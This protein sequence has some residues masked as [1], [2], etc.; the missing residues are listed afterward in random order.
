MR[1]TFLFLAAVI[2][3]SSIAFSQEV[4][5]GL[6][7]GIRSK[8]PT[9]GI[10]GAAY[11]RHSIPEDFLKVKGL[12][13]Q[14]WVGYFAFPDKKQYDFVSAKYG[15]G[16]TAYSQDKVD[17]G[18]FGDIGIA[19]VGGNNETKFTGGLGG[20]ATYGVAPNIKLFGLLKYNAVVKTIHYVGVDVG[21][22]Y[23][24]PTGK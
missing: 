17:L 7:L 8:E 6:N 11:F 19:F 5:A 20:F 21:V 14:L 4:G 16:Y 24:L 15:L 2:F 9:F 22:L 13:G 18:V 1:G 3:L 23:T 10:G 12:S